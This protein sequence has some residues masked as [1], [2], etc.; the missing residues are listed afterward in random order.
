MNTWYYKIRSKS[1]HNIGQIGWKMWDIYEQYRN[2]N[3]PSEEK[4]GN[5][6]YLFTRFCK[7]LYSGRTLY[8]KDWQIWLYPWGINSQQ[9]LERQNLCCIQTAAEKRKKMKEEDKGR[10]EEEEKMA[11]VAVK[12]YETQNFSG[13]GENWGVTGIQKVWHWQPSCFFPCPI[14]VEDLEIHLRVRPTHV[15][16]TFVCIW[17]NHRIVNS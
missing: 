7:I 16:N 12:P 8:F 10:R 17:T 1:S 6:T 9:Y 2:K 5:H 13:K 14:R 15:N 3:M 4:V 11:S